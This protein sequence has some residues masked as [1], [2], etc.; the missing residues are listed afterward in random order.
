LQ[1]GIKWAPRKLKG[2]P[3][4]EKT[5]MD[6]FGEVVTKREYHVQHIPLE[7]SGEKTDLSISDNDKQPQK[8]VRC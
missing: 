5:V 4:R 8:N 3:K 1:V 2:I 6:T 7:R